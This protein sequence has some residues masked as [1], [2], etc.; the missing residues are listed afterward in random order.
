[1]EHSTCMQLPVVGN[2]THFLR[3][4]TLM[5]T[6]F[7]VDARSESGNS[8]RRRVASKTQQDEVRDSRPG[9]HPPRRSGVITADQ[10]VPRG[11]GDRHGQEDLLGEAGGGAGGG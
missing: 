1:M 5:R 4:G 7:T 3:T 9:S 2:V 8:R 6:R 10:E 11:Q